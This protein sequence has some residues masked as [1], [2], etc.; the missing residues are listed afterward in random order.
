[1]G[2]KIIS[3]DDVMV[4]SGKDRGKIGKVIKIVNRK[5]G[6]RNML[7]AVVSGV[8]VCRKSVKANQKNDGGIIN[9]ERPINISNIALFDSALGIRTRVGYKFVNEKKVRFMKSSGKIIE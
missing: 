1:M 5:C 4:I 3:G 8:N 9:V 2:M 7:F 6:G